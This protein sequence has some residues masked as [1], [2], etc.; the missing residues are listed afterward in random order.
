MG[1][2]SQ[3]TGA[4][5]A[6]ASAKAASMGR[7]GDYNASND[8]RDKSAA[9]P[10]PAATSFHAPST[11][12]RTVRAA[13]QEM[14][15]T[16]VAKGTSISSPQQAI[17]DT[18]ARNPPERPPVPSAVRDA[19]RQRERHASRSGESCASPAA[20]S[21]AAASHLL[22]VAMPASIQPAACRL[23]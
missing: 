10:Y 8:V 4:A 16:P 1:R 5:T 17:E 2:A 3:S 20:T 13:I 12:S 21:N 11:S 6:A 19:S 15:I 7:R 14:L 23:C 9:P 22:L 18:L